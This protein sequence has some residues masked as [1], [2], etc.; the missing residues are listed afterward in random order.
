[1][2]WTVPRSSRSSDAPAK[3]VPARVAPLKFDPSRYAPTKLALV[4]FAPEKFELE[5]T[6]PYASTSRRSAFENRVRFITLR[7]R[8]A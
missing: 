8:S 4:R 7:L 2:S 6:P 5:N 3:F 1:M